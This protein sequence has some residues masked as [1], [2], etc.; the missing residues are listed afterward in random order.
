[1][2]ASPRKRI[3]TILAS[4]VIPVALI[5]GV[6][7][8]RA[9][10][11]PDQ[12]K[13]F[14]S[15]AETCSL[16]LNLLL[17]GISLWLLRDLIMG[18]LRK[19]SPGDLKKLGIILLLALAV[20]VC[21]APETHRLYYDEDIYLSIAQNMVHSGRAVATDFGTF[22]WDDYECRQWF[23]NKQ[24]SAL[25]AIISVVF[26]ITGAEERWASWLIVLLSTMTPLLIYFLT[27][28]LFNDRAALWA[29]LA[30]AL[31]PLSIIWSKVPS[32]ETATVFFMLLT[33]LLTALYCRRGGSALLG[34]MLFSLSFTVQF[35]PEGVLF[36]PVI[37]ILLAGAHRMMLQD[38]E[39]KK[40]LLLWFL[41]CMFMAAHLLHLLH[42]INEPW[43]ATGGGKFGLQYC[44]KNLKDNLGFFV[45]NREFPLILS[46]CACLGLFFGTRGD[47]R[48]RFVLFAWITAF[49]LP[50]IFFYAGSY[51]YG[52]DVRFALHILP[53]VIILAGLGLAM[54]AE[55]LRS[56]FREPRMGQYLAFLLLFTFYLSIPF[57]RTVHEESWQ[58]RWDHDFIIR[59]ANKLPR[60]AIVFFHSP[61]I[62]IQN[63]KRGAAQTYLGFDPGIVDLIFQCSDHVYFYLD[64]WGYDPELVSHFQYFFKHFEMTPVV[65]ERMYDREYI[66]YQIRRK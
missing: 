49:F 41:F 43:G 13:H 55:R 21:F 4:A 52:V 28:L 19:I 8:A 65:R 54:C 12:V 48:E 20:R 62:V 3:I 7:A 61:Y 24:P 34:A 63:C 58:A 39:E 42:F 25:P 16:W 37:C 59:E 36:I 15:R 11:S 40:S 9:R 60:D 29:A 66:I 56:Y 2:I 14:L 18:A 51:R 17:L 64:Y 32:A 44:A 26:F 30:A 46:L 5:A 53:P 57:I 50:Y 27:G 22:R 6:L 10:F 47:R 38:L 1:M 33:M 31:V 23:L 45:V 35:R